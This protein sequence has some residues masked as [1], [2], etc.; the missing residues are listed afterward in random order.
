MLLGLL[1]QFAQSALLTW[2]GLSSETESGHYS[3]GL[4]SSFLFTAP[5]EE[6]AKVL[7][8][9]PLYRA[10]KI[11]HPL[12][13]LG[14]AACTAAGFAAAETFWRVQTDPE[15]WTIARCLLAVPSHF[16]CAALWGA[17]L[18]TLTPGGWFSLSWLCGM[19]LHGLSDHFAFGRGLGL[20]AL[21]VPLM[22][23]Q[24][25]VAYAVTRKALR[26]QAELDSALESLDETALSDWAEP[27]SVREVWAALAPRPRRLHL[28]WVAVGVLVTTGTGLVALALSLYAGRAI[29]LDFSLLDEENVRSNGP[30]LLLAS[31]LGCAFPL[32]GYLVAKASSSQSVFEPALGAALAVLAAVLLL[33]FTTPIAAVVALALAPVAF[34][35]ASGGAWFGLDR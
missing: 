26:H 20:L 15:L 24:A 35:L 4:L 21:V 9:W 13:G 1:A 28:P 25:A 17:T 23:T 34:V 6:G 10:R 33:S 29:G 27:A 22:L 14:L 3:E 19:L 32:A 2:T 12:A 30:L 11:Q 5:L 31:A 8:L 16:L 18:G 7:A